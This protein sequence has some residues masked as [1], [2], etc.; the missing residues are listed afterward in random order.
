MPARR[1]DTRERI[2]EVALELFAERGY[3]DASMREIAARL[4]VTKAALYYHFKTKE[5]IL[6]SVVEDL[7]A[8]IDELAG[9]VRAQPLSAARRDE[10]LGR[11]V[12]LVRGRW[13]PLAR[14]LNENR[15]A[16]RRLEA[17]SRLRERG[18]VLFSLFDDG[19]DV[20]ARLRARLAVTAIIMGSLES[21]EELGADETELQDA[22][23]AVARG[24]LEEGAGAGRRQPAGER[25]SP[26]DLR[27]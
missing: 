13:R 25:T 4:G 17:G 7:A 3:D 27:P 15:A 18:R 16:L 22:A 1:G 10:A 26:P 2:Q 9:W 14:V 8:E 5:E 6:G 11:L 21:P 19:G 20:E 23:L 12:A 24:L